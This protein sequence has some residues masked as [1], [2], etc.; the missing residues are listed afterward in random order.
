MTSGARGFW[1][2]LAALAAAVAFT[3][4]L[5]ANP[6]HLN[7]LNVMALNVLVVTGLNLLIGFAGNISLGHAAFYGLGAYISGILSSTHGWDP[8]L[9]M[10]AAC[11]VV[12]LVALVIGI[13][14]LRLAGNYLVMATLGFNLIV[15]VLI[16]QLDEFT[17]G[18]SG[19]SGIPPLKIMGRSLASDQDFYWLAWGAALLGLLLARNLADS[20]VG[21]GLRALHDSPVAAAAVGVPTAA[22][23]VR[24]FVLSAVYASLAGSLYA[25]YFGIV[26][27]KSFDIFFS[28]ELVT[29]CLVGG[30][31]TLWGG[32]L[33]AAFLTPLPQVLHVFDEY[34]DI[35]FGGILMLLLIFQ[36]R[37]LAGLWP[38]RR[39]ARAGEGA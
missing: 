10:L 7:V 34:K 38:G 24:V 25:H 31:G 4:L 20:R 17:G 11:L 30:M 8:W 12:A 2:Q 18:P 9:A 29:M 19:F 37:G 39:A 26:A 23:K 36:P 27:P 32:F 21:R 14:T 15:T 1:W 3:P 5:V 13:P 16:L 33:G 28:V 6:Y 35:F 22:Y